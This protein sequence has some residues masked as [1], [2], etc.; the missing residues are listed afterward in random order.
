MAESKECG[1][2]AGRSQRRLE[3]TALVVNGQTVP[4]VTGD[5]ELTGKSRGAST[6]KRTVGGAAVGLIVGGL[7]RGGQGATEGAGVGA[8]AGAAAEIVTKV[9]H[10]ESAAETPLT[11]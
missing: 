8:G 4:I 10:V 2:F 9:A 7:A 5:Y 11:I 6:A 1:T 3:L